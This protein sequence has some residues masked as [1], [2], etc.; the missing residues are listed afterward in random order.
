[1]LK[2]KVFVDMGPGEIQACLH[3]KRL[4]MGIHEN[5]KADVRVMFLQT[6]DCQL[7]P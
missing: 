4:D 3:R 7:P 6:R 1:M 2:S 5:T